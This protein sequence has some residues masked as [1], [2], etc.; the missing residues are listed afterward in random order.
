MS[1]NIYHKALSLT[2]P[3]APAGQKA[4]TIPFLGTPSLPCDCLRQVLIHMSEGP[5]PTV[6]YD[7][8]KKKRKTLSSLNF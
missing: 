1:F 5:A 3:Y 8:Y 4:S 2:N 6:Q 7:F